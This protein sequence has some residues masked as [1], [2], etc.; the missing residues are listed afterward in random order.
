MIKYKNLCSYKL[1]LTMETKDHLTRDEAREA[2]KILELRRDNLDSIMIG[3]LAILIAFVSVNI[4]MFPSLNAEF[5]WV[6]ILVDFLILII[7]VSAFFSIRDI[8]KKANELAKEHKLEKFLDAVSYKDKLRDCK[9]V[10]T[11]IIIYI[12]LVLFGL[13]LHLL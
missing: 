6:G 2:I 10:A 13:L 9:V 11:V 5:V 8:E 4:I 12:I 7:A 1:N 3:A